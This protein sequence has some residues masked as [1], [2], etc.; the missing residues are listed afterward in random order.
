MPPRRAD[1]ADMR[2]VSFGVL[3]LALV[4]ATGCVAATTATARPSPF[5]HAPAPVDAAGGGPNA[6][7]VPARAT[8]ILDTALALRGTP[9][10]FGGDAPAAG[11]DCSGFVRFVFEQHQV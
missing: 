11:F 1:S 2:P 4:A 5:P 7:A 3:V 10:L 8:D 6:A 9:Y